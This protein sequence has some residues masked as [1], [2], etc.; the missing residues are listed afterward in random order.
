MTEMFRSPTPRPMNHLTRRTFLKSSAFAAAGVALSAR[1]WGQVA[2]AN[3]EI[4]VAVIGLNGRGKSHIA[5]L[6]GAKGAR[7]VAL[8]DV[9]SDVLAKRKEELKAKGVSVKTY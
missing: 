9:D 4:R 6:L 2:G 3:S 8:C 7:L 1:S 5:S